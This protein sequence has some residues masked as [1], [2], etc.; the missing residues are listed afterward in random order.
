MLRAL[1]RYLQQTRIRYSQDYM[2][3]TLVKNAAVAGKLV[4]LFHARFDPRLPLDREAR[5]M[6]EASL[7]AEIEV[8]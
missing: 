1:S 5:A 4:D 3:A 2:A 8:I 6:R 7:D